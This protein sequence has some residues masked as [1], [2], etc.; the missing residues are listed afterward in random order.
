MD[1]S[2]FIRHQAVLLSYDL[3]MTALIKCH[4]TH[5]FLAPF[6]FLEELLLTNYI[7]ATNNLA[8][9]DQDVLPIGL[10]ALGLAVRRTYVP[11][12]RL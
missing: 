12:C 2:I 6:L 7:T 4:L 1:Y 11:D 8:R 10:D 3:D 9:L 5:P